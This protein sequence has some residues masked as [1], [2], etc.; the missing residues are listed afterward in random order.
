[1]A[2]LRMKDARSLSLEGRRTKMQELKMEL[3]RASV[4]ANKASAKTK[5]LKRAVARLSTL[6][7]E[8]VKQK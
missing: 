1:M 7:R 6:N 3:I 8:G 4:T 2:L 5:E